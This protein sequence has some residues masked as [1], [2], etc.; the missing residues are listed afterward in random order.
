MQFAAKDFQ[1]GAAVLAGAGVGD[2]PAECLRHGLKP[3][4]DAE[5]RKAEVEQRRIE[6]RGAVGVDAGRPTGKHDRQ[7]IAGLDLLDR[8][9]CAG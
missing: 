7:R 8:W 1:L 5:H 4:A 3:V 9:R 2:G 6:L